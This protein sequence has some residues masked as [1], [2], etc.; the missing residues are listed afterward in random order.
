[1]RCV[2]VFLRIDVHE[3]EAPRIHLLPH[4]FLEA[5]RQNFREK[6]EDAARTV[7]IHNEIISFPNGYETEVG[8]RGI[9]LS[10]GQKQRIAIARA[11]AANPDILVLDDALSAVDAETETAILENLK[12]EIKSRTNIIIAHRI[13]AVKDADNILV[14]NNGTIEDAGKHYDLIHREGYYS[15]LYRLQSLE[16]NRGTN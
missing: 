3:A 8:E 10:G 9:T 6:I 1:M 7:R 14:I 2:Q 4:A 13:S 16:K 11:L 5:K 12:A 15:E